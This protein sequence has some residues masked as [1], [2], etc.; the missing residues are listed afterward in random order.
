[1]VLECGVTLKQKAVTLPS[2]KACPDGFENKEDVMSKP[3][4]PRGT[5]QWPDTSW[6]LHLRALVP[7]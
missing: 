1:M 3:G 6:Q 5:P 2:L 7:E 4:A